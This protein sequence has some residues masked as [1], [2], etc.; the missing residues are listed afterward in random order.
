MKPRIILP[1]AG[2]ASRF[3]GIPKELLPIASGE[4]CLARAVRV[5]S[6]IGD[7]VIVTNRQKLPWHRKYGANILVRWNPKQGDMWG[8][9]SAALEPGR[10]GGLILP[11][12]VV[13]FDVSIVVRMMLDRPFVLGLFTTWEAERFSVVDDE[14]VSIRTKPADRRIGLNRAWGV[15]F[16]SAEVTDF[17]LEQKFGH[18]DPAFQAVMRKFGYSTFTLEKFH[19][20]G[21]FGA[22]RT[23]LNEEDPW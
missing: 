23:Y 8:S 3:G 9:V 6:Q 14:T 12:T 13:S 21:T 18:Y 16:W 19:D 17:F 22:Y 15:A 5:A 20:I 2:E 11:D 10:A 7:P 1:A 4:T